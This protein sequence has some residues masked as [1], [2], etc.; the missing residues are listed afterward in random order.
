MNREFRFRPESAD[1]HTP[2]IIVSLVEALLGTRTSGAR[3]PLAAAAAFIRS[4]VE[5][6]RATDSATALTWLG[7]GTDRLDLGYRS[8]QRASRFASARTEPS[9]PTSAA[10]FSPLRKEPPGRTPAPRSEISL[11]LA[12]LFTGICLRGGGR[13][14][15][16]SRDQHPVAALQPRCLYVSRT[17]ADHLAVPHRSGHDRQWPDLQ[18]AEFVSRAAPNTLSTELPQFGNP[19]SSDATPSPA[20]QR[21]SGAFLPHP[22]R[23]MLID[24]GSRLL[25]TAHAGRGAVHVLLQPSAASSEPA[26]PDA[27][28]TAPGLL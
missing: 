18:Y 14:Q 4:V 19:T 22:G 7:A 5:R 13:F 20:N 24:S 15:S 17:S 26:G 21:Q 25:S 3:A 12:K 23:R 27:S 11:S 10:G 8:Q 28:R 9:T 16:R 1:R 6:N 2:G